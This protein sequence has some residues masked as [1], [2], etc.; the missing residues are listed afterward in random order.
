MK[1]K[2]VLEKIDKQ[3]STEDAVKILAEFRADVQK[4]TEALLKRKS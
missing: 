2:D 1:L 3:T 4:E